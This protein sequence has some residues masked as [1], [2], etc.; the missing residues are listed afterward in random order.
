M[1]RLCRREWNWQRIS[2]FTNI[3]GIHDNGPRDHGVWRHDFNSVYVNDLN[4]WTEIVRY[5]VLQIMIT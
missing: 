3:P 4:L 2:E 1:R 5:I